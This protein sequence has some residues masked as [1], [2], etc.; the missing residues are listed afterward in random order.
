MIKVIKR[1]QG[2]TIV[3]CNNCGKEFGVSS[4]RGYVYK[5]TKNIFCSYSCS[6]EYKKNNKTRKCNVMN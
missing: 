6:Q 2:Y 1:E 4:I 3:K 5:N